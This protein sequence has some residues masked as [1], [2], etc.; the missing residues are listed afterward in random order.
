MP[1]APERASSR[2]LVVREGHCFR[3]HR[4]AYQTSG[5]FHVISQF[6]MHIIYI[7]VPIFFFDQAPS[8]ETSVFLLHIERL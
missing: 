6:N 3:L 7:Y 1:V 4:F 2:T 8:A 5:L